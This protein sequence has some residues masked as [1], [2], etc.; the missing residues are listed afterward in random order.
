MFFTTLLPP[1][2]FSQLIP[3]NA[4]DNLTHKHIDPMQIINH[5]TP[6]KWVRFSLCGHRTPINTPQFGFVSQKR[7]FLVSVLSRS[8]AGVP[9]VSL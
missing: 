2:K 5:G 9:P 1:P 7:M 4:N 3:S 8:G 6:Q